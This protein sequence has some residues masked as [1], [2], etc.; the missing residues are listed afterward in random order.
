[1]TEP[2]Q[3]KRQYLMKTLMSLW[4]VAAGFC[5]AQPRDLD[6]QYLGP[7]VQEEGMHVWGSSPVI[8]PDGKVHLYVARWPM[9]TRPDF[10]G[11]FKD[12]EIAHYT[13]DSPEGPFT[14]VR[15]VVADQDGKFNSPH[16]P[17]INHIDGKYVLNFIV[18]ENDD[19]STQRIIMLV[20]DDPNGSWRP[21]AG[22]ESDGTILRKSAKVTDWNHGAKLGVSNPTLVKHNGKFLLY[23]KSVVPKAPNRWAYVYGVA[24][25][26]KLEGPY[27]H[28]PKPV[29][30]PTMQLEDAYAFEMDGGVR[31][32]S[33]DFGRSKGS[34]GGGLLWKSKTGLFF[35]AKNTTRA[36]EDLAHY[37]GKKSLAD[38]KVYRGKNDGHLERP[39]VLSIDG[40]PA[41][42]Y[43]ATGVSTTPGCG[44]SS[45]VFRITKTANTPN[46]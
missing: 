20:A 2:S 13:G 34:S 37:V 7:A 17:T 28:H 41:Y 12:C 40:S 39:Q 10:S 11:W 15:V 19:L 26:D 18:N 8:G 23:D 6:F 33:R 31:L 45:H 3:L 42:L 5:A 9:K 25:S 24:V 16:N 14:F 35:D 43:L 29:T 38:A 22:A 21:A 32:I 30:A 46:N 1:M 36:Y 27:R 44:S 4:I